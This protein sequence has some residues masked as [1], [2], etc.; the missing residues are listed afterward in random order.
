[1]RVRRKLV[2]FYAP[3]FILLP[4]VL[5]VACTANKQSAV[6]VSAGTCPV[7]ETVWAKPPE[8]SAVAGSSEYGYYF[9]NED[10][11]IWASAWWTDQEGN[12]LNAGEEGIKIG[13]FR[14]EGAELEI[15]GQRIDAQ[16][17]PLDAHIPCCYPTR[18]QSTGLVFPTEGCWEVM[19]TAE[20]SVLSFVIK[21]EPTG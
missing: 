19:A 16:A 20:N 21:V 13:W 6:D 3:I 5:L 17:P 9:V 15:S 12:Y 8:D 18:F 1:M 7:T 4:C 14:P 11:S 2:Q 10:R